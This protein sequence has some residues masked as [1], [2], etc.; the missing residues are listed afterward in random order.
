MSGT[1]LRIRR[2]Q[3]AL[4][5]NDV[6]GFLLVMGGDG[7][8]KTTVAEALKFLLGPAYCLLEDDGILL[9][10]KTGVSVWANSHGAAAE[11]SEQ[12]SPLP[13]QIFVPSPE[14]ASDPD[15]LEVRPMQSL[16]KCNL[17]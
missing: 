7:G 10:T 2:V 5:T 6:D 4:L 8:Y 15:K 1:A 9:I 3:K 11:V 17:H 12:L 14:E 16:P 13:H